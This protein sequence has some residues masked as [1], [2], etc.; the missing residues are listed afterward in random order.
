MGTTWTEA[1]RKKFKATMAAKRKEREADKRFGKESL[2]NPRS[3]ARLDDNKEQVFVA[4]YREDLE[5][6]R[7]DHERMLKAIK[8]VVDCTDLMMGHFATLGLSDRDRLDPIRMLTN[9]ALAG[10]INSQ[11]TVVEWSD[12]EDN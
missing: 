8:G 2:G 11:L 9:N 1:Q 5:K 7:Q 3:N 12:E 4:K 6:N 10:A